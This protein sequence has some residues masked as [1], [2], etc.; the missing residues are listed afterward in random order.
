VAT[1]VGPSA[2]AIGGA[3]A[4]PRLRSRQRVHGEQLQHTSEKSGVQKLTRA[5]ASLPIEPAFRPSPQ[6]RAPVPG[7]GSE[8]ERSVVTVPPQPKAKASA[9]S[10]ATERQCMMA[11]PVG[12]PISSEQKSSQHAK[13]SRILHC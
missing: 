3:G 8:D 10:D 13:P 12:N 1:R 5:V 9:N 7:S 11:T 6:G 4:R 2:A